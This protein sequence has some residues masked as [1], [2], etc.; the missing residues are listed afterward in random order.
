MEQ[1][2]NR[3]R[4]RMHSIFVDSH[5]FAAGAFDFKLDKFAISPT[6]CKVSSKN[7][8]FYYRENNTFAGRGLTLNERRRERQKRGQRP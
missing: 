8:L 4:S 6:T 7:S 1:P 5:F 2:V 3:C